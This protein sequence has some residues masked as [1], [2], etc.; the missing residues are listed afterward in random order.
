MRNDTTGQSARRWSLGAVGLLLAG[1]GLLLATLASAQSDPVGVV[2]D[3]YVADR[4]CCGGSR[5]VIRVNPQ[6]TQ[7]IIFCSGPGPGGPVGIA[8]D[9]AT[10]DLYVADANCCESFQGAVIRV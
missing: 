7:T 2:T 9:A 3:I 6:G 8:R 1:L 5:G 4:D 10:G